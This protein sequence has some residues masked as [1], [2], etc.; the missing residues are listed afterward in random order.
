VEEDS[1]LGP[2]K[3]AKGHTLLTKPGMR[4]VVEIFVTGSN[5][6]KKKPGWEVG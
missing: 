5:C 4:A 3:E 2:R 1:V 6:R